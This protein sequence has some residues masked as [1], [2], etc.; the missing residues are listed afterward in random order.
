MSAILVWTLSIGAGSAALAVAAAV[1]A[2]YLHMTIAA[3]I[4]VFVALSAIADVRAAA[5]REDRAEITLRY[6]GLVWTWTAL[7]LFITYAFGLG[8]RP[9]LPLFVACFLAGGLCIFVASILRREAAGDEQDEAFTRMARLIAMAQLVVTG[10]TL[11]TLGLEAFVLQGAGI[12]QQGWAASN[13]FLVS[14]LA[15][16]AV[17]LNMLRAETTA[18]STA[19]RP[20]AEA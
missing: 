9:W 20:T 4:A 5:T 7:N 12:R 8:W 10:S 11:S 15:L 17:S 3:A 14:S 19:V 18:E 2:Y 6:L 16:A 1:K 13:L